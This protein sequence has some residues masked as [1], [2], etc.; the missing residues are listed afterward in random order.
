M[1][2]VVWASS[3]AGMTR[4]W[5]MKMEMEMERVA[6]PLRAESALVLISVFMVPRRAA[7]HR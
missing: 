2:P 5:E 6:I 7:G 4:A 1:V 3:G